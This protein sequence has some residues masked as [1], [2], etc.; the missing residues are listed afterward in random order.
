MNIKKKTGEMPSFF[1]EVIEAVE[2]HT[3]AYCRTTQ[4]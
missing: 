4:E 1:D 3:D 2:V